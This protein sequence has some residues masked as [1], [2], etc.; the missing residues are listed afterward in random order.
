MIV[1][2]HIYYIILV[3]GKT[4]RVWLVKGECRNTNVVCR[5]TELKI[6]IKVATLSPAQPFI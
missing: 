1:I 6:N 4:F 5:Y 2:S 3:F